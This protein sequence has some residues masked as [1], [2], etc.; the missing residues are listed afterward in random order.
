M[1]N[2]YSGFWKDRGVSF[3]FAALKVPP[4]R[5][6]GPLPLFKQPL[7]GEKMNRKSPRFQL[8]RICRS[9]CILFRWESALCVKLSLFSTKIGLVQRKFCLRIEKFS[10]ELALCKPGPFNK[11]VDNPGF[12]LGE[13]VDILA[14]ALKLK[15]RAMWKTLW[16]V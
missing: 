4:Y 16:K 8:C 9:S 10:W 2:K 5:D 6:S 3:I 14:S 12:G 7:T 11:R 13:T 1:G 15:E